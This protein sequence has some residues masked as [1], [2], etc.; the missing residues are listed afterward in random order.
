M[1][2]VAKLLKKMIDIFNDNTKLKNL[3]LSSTTMKP[4]VNIHILFRIPKV[5]KK[6][7]IL[8]KAKEQCI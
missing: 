6:F 5:K 2:L 8:L 7:I 1:T 3:V 4:K